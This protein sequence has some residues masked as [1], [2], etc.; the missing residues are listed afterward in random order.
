[1][2]R[3]ALYRWPGPPRGVR[4]MLPPTGI[5]CVSFVFSCTL[6]LLHSYFFTCLDCPAFSF[7]VFT[8]NTQHTHPRAGEVRTRNPR[9]RSASDSL[10]WPLGHRDRPF[11]PWTVQPVASLYTDWATPDTLV[12]VMLESAKHATISYTL[13]CCFKQHCIISSKMILT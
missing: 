5:S 4:K 6:F 9:K 13:F 3:Y 12:Q 1:M 7:F 2:T 11:D 10:L 8:Y